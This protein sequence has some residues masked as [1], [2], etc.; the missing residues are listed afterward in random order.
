MPS[1]VIQIPDRIFHSDEV[2]MLSEKSSVVFLYEKGVVGGELER[3]TL[4]C[5]DCRGEVTGSRIVVS[6]T[7]RESDQPVI[8]FPSVPVPNQPVIAW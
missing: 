7:L 6:R 2:L 8:C 3:A 5:G 1:L 4:P